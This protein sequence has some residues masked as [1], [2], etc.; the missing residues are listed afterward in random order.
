MNTIEAHSGSEVAA[1]PVLDILV[2]DDDEIVREAIVEAL[3][4]AGH[5][6]VE[7]SNGEEALALFETRS[8]GL[9]LTDVRMPKLDGLTVFRRIRIQSPKTD[10]II[11]TSFATIGDVVGTLRAG[12]SDYLTKPFD[13]DAFVNEVVAFIAHR[14]AS[15]AA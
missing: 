12:A 4:S 7:A 11:M 8:F 1:T 15:S 2:A 14:R 6:V 9:V 5:R 10:V 3:T 13:L